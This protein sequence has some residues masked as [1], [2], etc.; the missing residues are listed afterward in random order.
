MKIALKVIS[1]V[2][3]AFILI[4]LLTL[5]ITLDNGDSSHMTM[6]ESVDY[7]IINQTV[8]NGV[9]TVELQ[10]DGKISTFENWI[11]HFSFFALG[12]LE[13]FITI[14]SIQEIRIFETSSFLAEDVKENEQIKNVSFTEEMIFDLTLT[15]E[16]AAELDYKNME[17]IAFTEPYKLF[18][19]AET[20]L[21]HADMFQNEISLE[22]QEG[23][24]S[25][26]EKITQ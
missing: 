6:S 15:K 18:N 12:V 10:N 4:V 24:I 19:Q 26:F 17:T 3:A 7:K 20:Y 5:V 13:D 25:N 2:L 14:D 23:F 1:G 22:K 21:I 8:V 11:N 16:K 9:A